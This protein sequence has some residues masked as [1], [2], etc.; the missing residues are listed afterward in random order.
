MLLLLLLINFKEF[1]LQPQPCPT[2]FFLFTPMLLVL[3]FV[4]FAT[5]LEAKPY[6]LIVE[7]MEALF[8]AP[9]QPRFSWKLQYRKRSAQQE[10]YNIQVFSSDRIVWDSGRAVYSSSWLRD[11]TGAP[12]TGSSLY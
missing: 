10:A 6:D 5:L 2:L 1:P 3:A 4:V 9:L 12:L 11:Y 7:Y 8:A